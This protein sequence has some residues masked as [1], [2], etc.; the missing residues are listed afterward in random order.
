MI[1]A[2]RGKTFLFYYRTSRITT[3]KTV[4]V[5]WFIEKKKTFLV[6]TFFGV[7]LEKKKKTF[8]CEI[9]RAIKCKF[10]TTKYRRT[11]IA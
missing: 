8:I 9:V 10:I 3:I 7:Y 5:E 1:K 2:S 6:G 4:P 11:A